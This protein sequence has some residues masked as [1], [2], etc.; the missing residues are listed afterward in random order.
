MSKKVNE[1]AALKFAR[2]V[3]KEQNVPPG[4]HDLSRVRI[5]IILPEGAS[6]DRL[7]GSEGNGQEAAGPA[8]SVN[9]AAALRFIQLMGIGTPTT[10]PLWKQALKEVT[11][12][13][14]KAK[15]LTPPEAKAALKQIH[16]EMPADARATKAT[17]AACSGVKGAIVEIDRLTKAD[18]A[19]ELMPDRVRA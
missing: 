4:N 12:L 8:D 9:A 3:L 7:E 17:P 18:H 1:A 16:E 11:E 10:F 5:V 2:A 14:L 6:V 13:D 19:F 15:D